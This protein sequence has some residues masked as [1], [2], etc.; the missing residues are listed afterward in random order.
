MVVTLSYVMEPLACWIQHRYGLDVHTRFE[1]TMNE[2]LQ[3]Q[4]L[5]HEELGIG[6][7][8]CCDRK[9]PITEWRDRLA[10]IDLEDSAHPKLKRPPP[11]LEN[12]ML[13]TPAVGS[14][15]GLERGDD[16]GSGGSS[17]YGALASAWDSVENVG[18]QIFTEDTVP[19]TQ[20]TSPKA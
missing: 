14:T 3:L 6:S 10:V 11:F 15:H 17:D 2:T 8:K 19:L 7:W 18:L 12:V 1:W 4:R 5:A 16:R 13:S 9:V 20:Y